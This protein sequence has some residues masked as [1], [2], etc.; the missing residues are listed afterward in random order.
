[1]ITNETLKKLY[2]FENSATPALFE[3][4]F[5]GV[6]FKHLWSKFSNT[7]HRVLDFYSMLDKENSELLINYLNK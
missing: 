4:I 5:G 3:E 2:S 6:M 7:R 1:M